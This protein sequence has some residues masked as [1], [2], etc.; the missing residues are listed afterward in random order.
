MYY[1]DD[2]AKDG[3]AAFHFLQSREDLNPKEIGFWGSSEGGMLSTQ[4]AA[5]SH[6]VAF[7]INSSGFM[8]PLWQTILY[9]SGAIPRQAG[10]SKTDVQQAVAFTKLWLRVA[11]TGRG[12]EQFLKMQQSGLNNN[13]NWFI[14]SSADFTSLEQMRWD[15]NHILVFNPLPALKKVTC[16]VLGMFGQLDSLTPVSTGM[17][18]M[19]RGISKGEIKDLTLKIFPNANHALTEADTGK[20]M[21]PGVFDTLRSWLLTR[22]QMPN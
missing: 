3:L 21:A 16:P 6:S 1:P 17:K 10:A 2:L 18:N 11:K 9:Q 14:Q 7:V 20:R 22:V 13:K 12:W 4:V 8:T 19:Q 15:W 5:Q